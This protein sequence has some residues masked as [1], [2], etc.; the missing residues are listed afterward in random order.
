MRLNRYYFVG[1][2]HF[3]LGVKGDCCALDQC[4]SLYWLHGMKTILIVLI[5]RDELTLQSQ[6]TFQ[7][8]GNNRRG[9]IPSSTRKNS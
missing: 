2:E 9:F 4:I 8:N 7:I 6:D 1:H 5:S 3:R